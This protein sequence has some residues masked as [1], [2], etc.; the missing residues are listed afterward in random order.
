MF[1]FLLMKTYISL[2]GLEADEFVAVFGLLDQVRSWISHL[3]ASESTVPLSC[4]LK[5]REVKELEPDRVIGSNESN[6]FLM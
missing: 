4:A 6:R 2:H 5:W 1:A 3:L